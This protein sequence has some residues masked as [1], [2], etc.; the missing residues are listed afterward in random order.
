MTTQFH[1]FPRSVFLI[2]C[3]LTIFLIGGFRMGI[4]MG[5][6]CIKQG[7]LPWQR[8]GDEIRKKKRV[9]IVGAGDAGE[10]ILREINDNV[11]LN[12]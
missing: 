3:I 8:N 7:A 4:R 12:Y 6:Q 10:K 1:G 5:L 11:G 2:D 9:V